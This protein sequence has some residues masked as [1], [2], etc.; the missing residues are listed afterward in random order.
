MPGLMCLPVE[1]RL[2]IL[3]YLLPN[4][5]VITYSRKPYRKEPHNR[6]IVI[7][8][9]QVQ[10]SAKSK[11]PT[12]LRRD[13]A[14]CYTAVM[15]VNRTIYLEAHDM[16]YRPVEKR[17]FEIRVE[18]H[19][20]TRFFTRVPAICNLGFCD[21]N[22]QVGAGTNLEL[23][24]YL[25]N[26]ERLRVILWSGSFYPRPDSVDA[27]AELF[28]R[29]LLPATNL[30][31]LE[32]QFNVRVQKE[33]G[34][35]KVL[36]MLD[37]SVDGGIWRRAIQH[38]KAVQLRRFTVSKG[39]QE[40]HVSFLDEDKGV[41]YTAADFAGEDWLFREYAEDFAS[42]VDHFESEMCLESRKRMVHEE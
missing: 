8:S 40:I 31:S 5:P 2:E 36:K 26:P 22:W 30:K 20:E 39:L 16:I 42:F 3:K 25:Q 34:Y 28:V 41:V 27:W 33:C 14:R 6:N 32:I 10:E 21:E 11:N 7:P 19:K 35:M 18:T 24:K 38:F 4:L 15:A 37:V 12:P 29:H 9:G 17:I 23:A 1:L 13:G